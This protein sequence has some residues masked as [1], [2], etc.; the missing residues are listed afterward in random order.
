MSK[1]V[2]KIVISNRYRKKLIARATPMET[3]LKRM[4]LKLKVKFIFQKEWL[5]GE[6]FYISDFYIPQIK[7][8]IEADGAHHSKGEQLRK[9]RK[10][11][12]YLKGQGIWTL[13][14]RNDSIAWM[15]LETLEKLLA[16]RGL[17]RAK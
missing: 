15:S 2:S 9:D 13:R 1:F 16:S 12:A 14:L 3:R 6:A 10:K 7:L 8:T 5:E 17:G 4:L 11:S